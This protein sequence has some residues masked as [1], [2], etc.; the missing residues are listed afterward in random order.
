MVKRSCG[1]A[2]NP[3]PGTKERRQAAVNVISECLTH[4]CLKKTESIQIDSCS[5]PGLNSSPFL[6]M[7]R[8]ETV[9]IGSIENVSKI[10]TEVSYCELDCLRLVA[11]FA[12]VH[13]D[14]IQIDLSV[15][16]AALQHS[17]LL[18]PF[19]SPVNCCLKHFITTI[20]FPCSLISLHQ[21]RPVHA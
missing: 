1:V 6:C 18:G 13:V 16:G 15:L 5:L 19:I 20:L 7:V 17:D 9:R 12:W 3:P 21:H 14:Q 10:T 8:N 2:S 11:T 4:V